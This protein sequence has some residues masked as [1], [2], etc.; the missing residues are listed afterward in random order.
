[1]EKDSN[2]SELSGHRVKER[3]S[4]SSDLDEEASDGNSQQEVSEGDHQDREEEKEVNAVVD[5]AENNETQSTEITSNEAVHDADRES[6]VVAEDILLATANSSSRRSSRIMLDGSETIDAINESEMEI[7]DAAEEKIMAPESTIVDD[8]PKIAQESMVIS[9]GAAAAGEE[10]RELRAYTQRPK[11]EQQNKVSEKVSP[12]ADLKESIDSIGTVQLLKPGLLS[13]AMA[14]NEEENDR[15]GVPTVALSPTMNAKKRIDGNGDEEVGWRSDEY[16]LGMDDDSSSP[17]QKPGAFQI[18]TQQNGS[19]AL[20]EEPDD[21][22]QSPS[23]SPSSKLANSGRSTSAA[24]IDEESLQREFDNK[25]KADM[26][27]SAEY[28]EADNKQGF[29]QKNASEICCVSVVVIAGLVIGLFVGLGQA[30]SRNVG[31]ITKAPTTSPTL[32]DD[33][34]YLQVLFSSISGD[35]VF[36]NPSSPQSK[37]F[38]M[39]SRESHDDIFDVREIGDQYLAERYALRVLYYST[40]GDAWLI[41]DHNFNSTLNTCSW[42]NVTQGNRL[43]CNDLGEVTDLFLNAVGLNG[44]IP[45]ELGVLSSLSELSLAKNSLYGTIPSSLGEMKDMKFMQLALNSI[46]GSI[47]SSFERFAKLERF[48]MHVNRLSGSLPN[49]WGDE[50][51]RLRI[52][53]NKING[54][55]PEMPKQMAL[56]WFQVSDNAFTGTLPLNLATQSRLITLAISNN[57]FEGTIP[58]EYSALTLMENFVVD[59]NMLYGTLPSMLGRMTAVDWFWVHGNNFSGSLPAS[60]ETMTNATQMKYHNNNFNGTLPDEWSALESLVSLEVFNNPYLEG[61]VP[62]SYI[63]LEALKSFALAGTRISGGLSDTLCNTQELDS[64]S[65]ECGGATPFIECPCCTTCCDG[66]FCALQ[67]LNET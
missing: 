60:F 21:S 52:N 17:P 33:D 9:F 63:G 24:V 40:G 44:T 29:W 10:V 3:K 19:L 47:P 14:K 53:R 41:N 6:E 58:N 46:S 45:S 57:R 39:I 49:L 4:Y 56:D 38:K 34:Q 23:N 61:T 18:G 50:F 16:D 11:C 64:L 59:G 22:K 67:N 37:A 48:I 25:L 31:N 8:A 54:T 55:I 20:S 28:D 12:K 43:L 2:E 7:D 42:M 65:A 1:M 32:L 51:R 15:D 30:S 36:R 66:D 13:T 35:E 26:M 5:K 27:V 62:S